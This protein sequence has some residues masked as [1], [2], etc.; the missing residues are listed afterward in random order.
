MR[1]G[2]RG[3]LRC[4]PAHIMWFEAQGISSIL[5]TCNNYEKFIALDSLISPQL[6]LH[7]INMPVRG[8]PDKASIKK[9]KTTSYTTKAYQQKLTSL[10]TSLTTRQCS[11]REPYVLHYVTTGQERGWRHYWNIPRTSGLSHWSNKYRASESDFF[12][13][14]LLIVWGQ[15]IT[16]LWHAQYYKASS[17]QYKLMSCRTLIS[18]PLSSLF[19]KE[20]SYNST[21]TAKSETLLNNL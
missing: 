5:S 18:L 3:I 10:A 15:W 14:I 9:E 8:Q 4:W 12:Q 11:R 17:P 19:L 2:G 13:Q 16:G 20:K 1:K 7:W 21:Q 6:L